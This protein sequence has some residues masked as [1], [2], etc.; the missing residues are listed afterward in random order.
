[1]KK[2]IMALIILIFATAFISLTFISLNPYLKNESKIRV[3]ATFYPL[4]YLT[5]KIGGE[6]VAVTNLIP[7]NM[8]PHH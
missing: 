6:K 7:Y 3:V 2:L 8:D 5:E 1:M 4:A